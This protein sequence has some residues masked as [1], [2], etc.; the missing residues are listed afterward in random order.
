MELQYRSMTDLIIGYE[1]EL[2]CQSLPLNKGQADITGL[3]A[4]NH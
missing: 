4:L 1:I 2:N 3:K